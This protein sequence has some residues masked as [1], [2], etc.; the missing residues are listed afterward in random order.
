MVQFQVFGAQNVISFLIPVDTA[1]IL[2]YKR[3]FIISDMGIFQCYSLFILQFF[4][5][6]IF[7]PVPSYMLGIVQE[8]WTRAT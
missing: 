7:W 4:C 5:E 6:W 3:E 8:L 1:E 2:L